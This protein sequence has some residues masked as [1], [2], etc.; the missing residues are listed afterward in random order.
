ME[1][2]R[3]VQDAP[4]Y[5]SFYVFPSVRQVVVQVFLVECT[6]AGADD[7]F[8]QREAGKDSNSWVSKLCTDCKVRPGWTE[9]NPVT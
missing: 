3:R 4:I 5:L 1:I 7:L 6:Y 8:V 9:F 2:E